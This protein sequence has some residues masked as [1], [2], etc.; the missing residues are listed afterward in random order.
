MTGILVIFEFIIGCVLLG[1][2]AS[3]FIKSSAIIGRRLGMS[4][5]ML[6]M[7]LVG[8]GTSLPEILVSVIAASRGNAELAI[9]N[10]IGSNIANC[11]VVVSIVA[12]ISPIAIHSRLLKREFPIMVVVTLVV[13]LLVWNGY[14][15]RVDGS[16]LLAAL[17]IYLIWLFFIIPKYDLA[18]DSLIDEFRHSEQRQPHIHATVLWWFF[19]LASLL[20]GSDLLVSG[21]S[22][23]ASWLGISDLVIGLTIVAVGTALPELASSVVAAMNKEHDIAIGNVVGSNIFNLLAVLAMPALISPT[24]LSNAVRYRDYPIMLGFTLLLWLM[25]VIPCKKHR[26]GRLSGFVL[27]ALYVGYIVLLVVGR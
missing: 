20:I 23:F 5:L 15:T 26:L 17:V 9:G 24:K 25:A 21:A 11:G 14:L 12:L 19:G 2:G 18:H 10:A 1:F 4:S 13:G 22:K 3:R 16:L 6:G 8:F 7:L 27:L